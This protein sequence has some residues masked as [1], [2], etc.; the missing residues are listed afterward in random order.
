MLLGGCAIVLLATAWWILD[1]GALSAQREAS[2]PPS[3]EIADP[4]GDEASVAPELP[5]P[6]AVAETSSSSAGGAAATDGASVSS[7]VVLLSSGAPLGNR[8]FAWAAEPLNHTSADALRKRAPSEGEFTQTFSTTKDGRFRIEVPNTLRRAW[9][10][11]FSE[12]YLGQLSDPIELDRAP[13]EIVYPGSRLD[14]SVIDESGSAVAGAVVEVAIRSTEQPDAPAV[15]RRG[16][17]NEHGVAEL[18]TAKAGE[19]RILASTSEGFERSLPETVYL[20]PTGSWVQRTLRLGKHD[21]FGAMRVD[22]TWASGLPVQAYVMELRDKKTGDRRRRLDAR[23]VPPD[24]VITE[25][26]LGEY[27]VRLV[28]RYRE[29][30]AL[31]DPERVAPQFVRLEP[32]ALPRVAFRPS[33]SARAVLDFGGVD[34]GHGALRVTWRRVDDE[35]DEWLPIRDLT[36]LPFG[37]E[38]VQVTTY[39]ESGA[40]YCAPPMPPGLVQFRVLARGSEEVLFEA[41]V[42]LVE[43][44]LAV[45]RF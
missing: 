34:A 33:S 26:P 6:R 10:W 17:T 16:S 24:G 43:G 13:L 22:V 27:Q 12:H 2:H 42:T 36:E 44:E 19:A 35:G 29:S 41:S 37:D 5:S 39:A 7:G 38:G 31:Y 3:P 18:V 23:D 28:A 4:H 20:A 9:I 11:Q 40:R 25:L 8:R 32:G 30:P 21:A 45:A 1:D 14:L 15:E